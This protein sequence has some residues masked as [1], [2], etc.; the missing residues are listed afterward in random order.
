[1]ENIVFVLTSYICWHL[2]SFLS[3]FRVHCIISS[4]IYIFLLQ[5]NHRPLIQGQT[6][7]PPTCRQS[8]QHAQWQRP[9]QSPSMH[10]SRHVL[11]SLVAGFHRQRKANPLS[12]PRCPLPVSTHCGRGQIPERKRGR[13]KTKESLKN[14]VIFCCWIYWNETVEQLVLKWFQ[15]RSVKLT[16]HSNWLCPHTPT[17]VF[18]FARLLVDTST[19]R[20][21]WVHS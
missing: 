16:P 18:C 8:S 13:K 14:L 15:T 9:V 6:V 5:P 17:P 4:E 10:L 12:V 11:H 2:Q 19:R 3:T 20:H 21:R 1:M 7:W